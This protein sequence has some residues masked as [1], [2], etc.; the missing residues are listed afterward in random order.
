[1]R[2]L[3]SS[4]ATLTLVASSTA[5]TV[6]ACGSNTSQAQQYADKVNNKSVTIDD[7]I[8][9]AAG[10][11]EKDYENKTAQEDMQAIDQAIEAAGYLKATEVQNFSFDNTK[12]LTTG[13]NSGIGFNVTAPDGSTAKG[14][15]NVIIEHPVQTLQANIAKTQA[16]QIQEKLAGKTVQLNDNATTTYENET[17]A[18]NKAGV[19]AALVQQKILTQTEAN[20]V[21]FDNTKK[22]TAGLNNNIPFTVKADGSTAT[23]TFN[24]NVVSIAS[25]ERQALNNKTVSLNDLNANTSQKAVKYENTKTTDPVT[26]KALQDLVYNAYLSKIAGA[27]SSDVTF[28]SATLM[29]NK[30]VQVNFNVKDKNKTTE[31][32]TIDVNVNSAL[33]PLPRQNKNIADIYNKLN[34]LLPKYKSA[35]TP[36]AMDATFN[37]ATSGSDLNQKIST[38]MM[39]WLDNA[40]PVNQTNPQALQNWN[41]EG[42]SA[43]Q[44]NDLHYSWNDQLSSDP[45]K[46]TPI[47]ITIVDS[48]GQSLNWGT[49]YGYTNPLSTKTTTEQDALLHHVVNNGTTISPNYQGTYDLTPQDQQLDFSPTSKTYADPNFAPDKITQ[50]ESTV[51]GVKGY[52]LNQGDN[53]QKLV[54]EIDHDMAAAYKAKKVTDIWQNITNAKLK[55]TGYTNFMYAGG[56]DG[57]ANGVLV[58]GQS[59]KVALATT[60]H[61]RPKEAQWTTFDLKI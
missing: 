38:T 45:K 27:K 20:Y 24:T 53:Y 15:L 2:K 30:T 48:S 32:G 5:G 14:N 13:T 33:V 41:K 19:V 10:R 43:A 29:L 35:K 39:T 37:G 12:N 51:G 50:Y 8:A 34:M 52:F 61:D 1:M 4:L 57:T 9:K 55:Q 47:Q 46:P 28:N 56:T 26:M 6:V 58:P 40:H 42:L 49:I 25:Q 54:A 36:M 3:L 18:Y 44:W 21:T 22:L 7:Q 60:A 16:D 31:S 23:G 59:I 17:T 11:T